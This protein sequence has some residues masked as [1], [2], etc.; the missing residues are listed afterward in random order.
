MS[1]V[2]Y[3]RNRCIERCL[4]YWNDGLEM[5]EHVVGERSDLVKETGRRKDVGDEAEAL[6]ILCSVGAKEKLLK[7]AWC[8]RMQYSRMVMMEMKMVCRARERI[9]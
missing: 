2:L 5:T 9:G 6:N 8:G 7:G 3:C 4:A 1:C